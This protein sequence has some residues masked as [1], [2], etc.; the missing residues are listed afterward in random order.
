MALVKVAVYGTVGKSVSLNPKAT[1]GATV[2]TNLFLPDGSI[3][4]QSSLASYLGVGA[5]S[6]GVTQ[7]RLLI[8]LTVGDDHPMY[9]RKDTLT[10]RG[11]LYV[12]DA[13]T[14]TRLAKGST[15]QFLQS[16]AVDTAWQT[17]SPTITLSTDLSGSTTLTNLANGTLAATIVANAV[18]DTKLRQSAGL[19]VIGRSANTTGNVADI[20][21]A[22]DGQALR[23]SGTSIGFG[24]IDLSSVNAITGDLPFAN[25]TQGAALSVLGVTG[26]ATADVASIAAASDVTVLRRAG[27]IVAFGTIDHT[28]I[29]DFSSSVPQPA[30]PTGAVGLVAVNGSAATFMRSDGAPA[31]S[32]A[33]APTWSNTHTFSILPVLP[34][35]SANTIFAGPTTG[36]AATPS[37][38]ALVNADI[39][40]ALTGKT[41]NGLTLTAVSVGFTIAGGAT[42]KTLTVPLDASVSGTNTG[43]QTIT[44]TGDVTGSGTGSFAATIAND[45][46]TY[47]KMQNISAT[48]RVLGRITTGSGDTEELTGANLATII[49]TSLGANPS[50]S[51]GLTAVNGTAGT[52]L[53]SDGAPALDQG[54]VPTWTGQHTFGGS[55]TIK[56]ILSS[57]GT[58]VAALRAINGSFTLNIG[59][60]NVG[61]FLEMPGAT[62]TNRFDFYVGGASRLAVVGDGHVDVLPAVGKGLCVLKDSGA[63]ELAFQNTAKTSTFSEF[64][65]DTTANEAYW[66][67]AS[68]NTRLAMYA[69]GTLALSVPSTTAN[70]A[71]NIPARLKNYT[72]SGLPSAPTS[73]A[74]AL[75]FVTDATQTAILGLGL[76]V[77]GGGANKVPVYSDGTNWIII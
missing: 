29:S 71:F 77:V 69:G 8:G 17:I 7:H 1:D 14:V 73:G 70:V 65:Y 18:I 37:F 58:N 30:N 43:D 12:R 20:T 47:A 67:T 44:L 35:Q 54:I 16:G 61:T 45:A 22:S 48:S 55:G 76:T 26:N 64:G 46:V 4:T 74:G 23:R 21:A 63:F 49:G 41:Y 72:V 66:F 53:R 33:I 10:T 25:L 62:G 75:A 56:V 9:A 60:D 52:Y 6:T 2:G 24:A 68:T 36:S 51:V 38:R 15:G 31:L 39:P 19:S 13:T 28:Y 42:G 40:T 50:A 11:D 34:N 27:T 57:A 5:V 59:V 3:A 32:Q